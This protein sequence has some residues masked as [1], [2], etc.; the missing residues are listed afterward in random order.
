MQVCSLIY[1]RKL[2][3]RK[4]LMLITELWHCIGGTSYLQLEGKDKLL[5]LGWTQQPLHLAK[6]QPAQICV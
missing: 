3:V 2:L 6:L 1:I 5:Q 4:M